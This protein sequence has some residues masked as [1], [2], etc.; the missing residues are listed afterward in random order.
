MPILALIFA[1]ALLLHKLYINVRCRYPA[2]VNCWFCNKDT[3]VAYT[4]RNSW[5]CSD[6]EQY[7]GFKKDGDYN[8]D[9]C[10][11]SSRSEQSTNYAMQ[12][13][14][15]A[16]SMARNNGLCA[17]CNEAQRLKVEKLAQFEPRHESRFEQELKQYKKQLEQQF[18]L[19]ASCERHVNKV[20][21][22]K[23]K[24]VLSSTL[25]NL[26]M[27]GASL[28]K[29]P[30]FKRLARVQQQ[31]RLRRLQRLMLLLSLLQL[32]CLLCSLPPAT[33]AQFEALLGVKLAEP[34]YF[35]YSH[36]LTLLRVLIDYG[37]N[38]LA[39]QP[40]LSKCLLFCSTFIKML[41]YSLG[42]TQLQ[43]SLSVCFIDVYPYAI[44]ALSFVHHLCVGLKF[45]R[46]TLLLSLWSSYAMLSLLR[47]D[48]YIALL[49]TLATLCILLYHRSQQQLL[50]SSHNESVG[51]SF[52]RL[53][54]DEQLSDDETMSM[55]SQQL[56]TANNSLTPSLAS[57][58]PTPTA[59]KAFSQVAPSVL[60]LDS[61]H[62]STAQRMSATPRFRQPPM[63]PIYADMSG[64]LMDDGLT[65]SWQRSSLLK[66]SSV[67]RLPT[68]S[69]QAPL[70]HAPP[71]L[72]LPSRLPMHQQHH[73][74]QHVSAW[75]QA[76]C[77]QPNLLEPPHTGNLLQCYEDKQLSRSSS[78]S[79]GFESQPGR[80][81]WDLRLA[82]APPPASTAKSSF[83]WEDAAQ[84]PLASPLA[85]PSLIHTN[86]GNS[87]NNLQ[88]GDLLRRWMDRNSAA[89]QTSS[90]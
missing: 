5:T 48:T 59:S 50:H 53:C 62:L 46:V 39:E 84:R 49:F 13:T 27:K 80:P 88:P 26:Y 81:H 89:T 12:G 54:A 74:Q 38:F 36:V 35:V 63:S 42:L 78:Q 52:H 20:L 82:S 18:Q 34:L 72:L 11:D 14:Q 86:Y 3:Q 83:F 57:P 47:L 51:D 17:Q 1:G 10:N 41:L 85:S 28:L 61:L 87:N 9:I 37:A 90:G 70:H 24:I 58:T 31:Q 77:A 68:R 23:K 40:R 56:S 2:K 75:V 55:V 43:S 4:E 30:H 66:P 79:S 19:C 22:E 6:C 29:Q 60:S 16:P 21:C 8:R 67:Q 45:T 32:I 65:S 76:N 15:A 25:L 44:M 64:S 7:N 73:Q 33:R 71:S 69:T